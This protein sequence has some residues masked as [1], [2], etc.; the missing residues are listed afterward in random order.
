[1]ENDGT[2]PLDVDWLN[3]GAI[4][5]RSDNLR[6]VRP[7]EQ[8]TEAEV[9]ALKAAAAKL[10]EEL[11]MV[12]SKLQAEQQTV[13]AVTQQAN[14]WRNLLEQEQEHRARIEEDRNQCVQ[15]L[16]EARVWNAALE[17]QRDVA[18]EQMIRMEH[19]LNGGTDGEMQWLWD[20]RERSTRPEDAAAQYN[21]VAMK[22]SKISST[23]PALVL[24]FLQL[25]IAFDPNHS[26]ARANLA[27]VQSQL[28]NY[29]A[30]RQQYE[31]A[32]QHN[33]PA[34]VYTQ[35]ADLL[36]T[37]F[38]DYAGARQQLDAALR[39]D[40][41]NGEALT[42]LASLPDGGE[43]AQ[44]AVAFHNLEPPGAQ[45]ASIGLADLLTHQSCTEPVSA[46]TQPVTHVASQPEVIKGAQAEK[47]GCHEQARGCYAS[48]LQCDPLC[49]EARTQLTLLANQPGDGGTCAAR[50]HVATPCSPVS[51]VSSTS[52]ASSD[53]ML[54]DR[55]VLCALCPNTC[56]AFCWSFLARTLPATPAFT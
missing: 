27:Y 55:H 54:V 9:E 48:A 47:L 36:A 18:L 1:M 44:L 45:R 13:A 29:D 12:T 53:F 37:H 39:V 7:S 25:A 8:T 11:A 30:A 38:A 17:R 21:N 24:N 31:V 20:E 3:G 16:A 51:P 4:S 35:F 43:V 49:T 19:R 6:V 15:T 10:K 56:G 23:D 52:T 5:L 41:T 26:A 2:C 32:V 22:L 50:G 40:P 28:Q 42:Q 14:A 33:P 46:L 34:A